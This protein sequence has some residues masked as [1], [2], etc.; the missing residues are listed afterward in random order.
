MA[1][2]TGSMEFWVSEGAAPAT[3][4]YAYDVDGELRRAQMTD[5]SGVVTLTLV[6]AYDTQG[7]LVQTHLTS[8]NDTLR[9]Q[10]TRVSLH[11]SGDVLF[12]QDDG[13]DG[14]VDSRTT[15]WRVDG[16][17]FGSATDSDADGKPDSW[18]EV[19]N[20]HIAF[21]N[22]AVEEY[23]GVD[24]DSVQR[25]G[26]DSLGRLVETTLTSEGEARSSRTVWRGYDTLGRI[27][28]KDSDNDGDGEADSHAIWHWWCPA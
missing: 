17:S 26:Y 11:A 10:T 1:N 9:G 2:C 27:L 20:D 13:D 22:P 28:W 24:G 19:W 7:E 23:I 16:V 15:D 21:Q 4:T 5:P 6:Y 14:I 3:W 25:F 12:E 8:G 18:T